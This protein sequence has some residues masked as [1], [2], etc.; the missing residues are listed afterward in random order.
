M[1]MSENGCRQ[2]F[3]GLLWSQ[4]R[5]DEFAESLTSARAGACDDYICMCHIICNIESSHSSI[6]FPQVNP[7]LFM[8][9]KSCSQKRLE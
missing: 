8:I 7:F 9:A 1:W 3:R 2:V 6:I 4:V 5:V